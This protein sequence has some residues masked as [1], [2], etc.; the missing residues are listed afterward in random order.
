MPEK[1]RME[2]TTQTT[3]SLIY[4]L[5]SLALSSRVAAQ[6]LNVFKNGETADAD[7]INANF[8]L[9]DNQLKDLESRLSP[10]FDGSAQYIVVDCTSD[11]SALE[12]AMAGVSKNA[13]LSLYVSGR[14][15]VSSV[16][17]GRGQKIYVIGSDPAQDKLVA[18]G[19]AW[20][21]VF[22]EGYMYLSKIGIVQSAGN[23][24]G[25]YAWSGGHLLLSNVTIEAPNSGEGAAESFYCVAAELGSTAY[26]SGLTC[27]SYS[28]GIGL[29]G[30]SSAWLRGNVNVAASG[31]SAI[32]AKASSTFSADRVNLTV[33]GFPAF[34][35]TDGS[36]YRQ[37]Y[38]DASTA[39]NITGDINVV[40]GSVLHFDDPEQTNHF[41]PGVVS[42]KDSTVSL[43]G[44]TTG[45]YVLERSTGSITPHDSVSNLT[46]DARQSDFQ[47]EASFTTRTTADLRNS[48]MRWSGDCQELYCL[49]NTFFD[50]R[51]NSNLET[52]GGFYAGHKC[53]T[54]MS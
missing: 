2:V 44:F 22:S 39:Y 11:S 52:D 50:C 20:A 15:S 41:Q 9:L 30:A 28:K 53:L 26:I 46:I 38:G 45:N 40:G 14:C 43:K 1:K 27:S 29:I 49:G 24:S 19:A 5:I 25:A 37:Q 16:Y 8:S 42:V 12:T 18:Y 7:E 51:G 23:R 48:T 32:A 54:V 21:P 31:G 17:A 36:T 13:L 33:L 6:S 4:I 35:L 3:R 47:Y 10:G 34:D